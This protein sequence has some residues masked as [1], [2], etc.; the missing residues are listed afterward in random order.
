MDKNAALC[1]YLNLRSITQTSINIILPIAIKPTRSGVIVNIF[2]TSPFTKMHP[3][4]IVSKEIEYS[5][6]FIKLETK[7]FVSVSPFRN[8][9]Q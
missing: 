3:Q 2:S 9:T 6:Q 7:S 1:V 8:S 4:I 5:M